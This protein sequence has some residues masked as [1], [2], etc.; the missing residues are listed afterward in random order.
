MGDL[1]QVRPTVP[2]DFLNIMLRGWQLDGGY[3][4][5]EISAQ[6]LLVRNAL[7]GVRLESD[8]VLA[9]S[10]VFPRW[11]GHGTAWAYLSRGIRRRE[12]V[13]I[14]HAI[15]HHLQQALETD[16]HRVEVWAHAEPQFW[17]DIATR[18]IERMGFEF[19][20]RARK[21]TPDARDMMI[22]AKVR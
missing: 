4:M 16:Y 10:G 3:D 6:E 20:G 17:C 18:W 12:W 15:E 11:A 13:A 8:T 22:F 9:I 21:F 19:E 7:T 5:E 1:I 14:T 2:D